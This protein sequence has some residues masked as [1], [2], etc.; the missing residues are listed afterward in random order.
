MLMICKHSINLSDI[1]YFGYNLILESYV[2]RF[3]YKLDL[4]SC[5]QKSDNIILQKGCSKRRR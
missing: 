5:I 2:E 3:I 1:W 4:L